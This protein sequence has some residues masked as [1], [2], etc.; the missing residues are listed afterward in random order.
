MRCMICVEKQEKKHTRTGENKEIVPERKEEENIDRVE[1]RRKRKAEDSTDE[2]NIDNGKVIKYKYIGETSRSGYERLREHWRQFKDFSTE[3]HILKHYLNCHTD[4]KIEEMR[5]TFRIIGTY[6]SSF[7]RQIGESIQINHNLLKGVNLLN[8]RNEYSRCR[9]PRI[10][11]DRE[12]LDYIEEYKEALEEKKMKE[13]IE[14]MKKLSKKKKG[15]NWEKMLEGIESKEKETETEKREK[16]IG[17]NVIRGQKKNKLSYRVEKIIKRIETGVS[18]GFETKIEKLRKKFRRWERIKLELSREELLL[19]K[20]AQLER[21]P[22][23]E[24]R[25]EMENKGANGEYVIALETEDMDTETDERVFSL[26]GLP[27][28]NS[29]DIMPTSGSEKTLK[30]AR[31]YVKKSV[32]KSVIKTVEKKCN[33]DSSEQRLKTDIKNRKIS[34]YFE[35]KDIKNNE[36]IVSNVNK[37]VNTENDK[38]GLSWATSG[39]QLSVMYSVQVSQV[40]CKVCANP[41]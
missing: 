8:S 2:R 32:K 40:E 41:T 38:L 4:I 21:I 34:V 35:Q 24:N 19:V 37:I 15:Q 26:P 16:K 13:K 29:D 14:N 3:S 9:I 12:K 10:G 22:Q 11:L 1:R 23:R 30:T 25:I 31:K 6:R 27:E 36:V 20:M 33:S 28:N 5:M 18:L 17:E 7:E 39:C